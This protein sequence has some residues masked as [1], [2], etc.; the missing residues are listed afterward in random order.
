MPSHHTLI[1]VPARLGSSRLPRK[2]LA[3]IGGKSMLQR[4]LEQC[5]S[6]V[7]IDKVF[8]CTDSEQLKV[9]CESLGFPV[10]ITSESCSSGTDRIASVVDKLSFLAWGDEAPSSDKTLI[11]NVQG[12]QPFVDPGLIESLMSDFWSYKSLPEVVTPVYPLSANEVNDP[13][14]VKV[15]ITTD[16]RALYFSRSVLPYVRDVEPDDWS[17]Y[18]TFW[19]H[20]GV[21]GFRGDI[22]SG[23]RFMPFS[24][25]ERIEK[26][27]QLRLIES[28]RFVR[29]IQANC[30]CHSVDTY[31]QL[32]EARLIADQ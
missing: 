12:D 25:L 9:L 8:V 2:V 32:L 21:Y 6:V 26:L 29:T 27:E 10:V 20:I 14:I 31:E 15:L 16:R 11:I 3:D 19:G 5:S 30:K 22:L 4:V 24:P 13:N 28:G 23:W 1:A 17:K 18:T 7:G